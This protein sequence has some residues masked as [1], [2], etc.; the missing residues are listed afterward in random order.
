MIVSLFSEAR[1]SSPSIFYIEG[2]EVF[3]STGVSQM[4]SCENDG[5]AIVVIGTADNVKTLVKDIKD[6]FDMLVH[7]GKPDMVSRTKM[8]DGLMK[9]YVVLEDRDKICNYI[10]SGTSGMVWK[11]IKAICNECCVHVIEERETA[12]GVCSWVT[13]EDVT[14][15]LKHT[16][17]GISMLEEKDAIGKQDATIIVSSCIALVVASTSSLGILVTFCE[18][19]WAGGILPKVNSSRSVSVLAL[20]SRPYAT[21]LDVGSLMRHKTLK[22]VRVPTSFVVCRCL[23][24]KLSFQDDLI[25][26]DTPKKEIDIFKAQMEEKFEMSD[27]GLLAYY[28]GIKVTQTGGDISIKQ[29]AYANKILK[30]AGMIDSNETLI[31][32]DLGIRLSKVTEGTR[33]SRIQD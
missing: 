32:M 31:P 18:F 25:I 20:L 26:T 13:F 3:T 30:E 19:K 12:I 4:E 28:L 9:D 22:P 14:K 5:A 1:V 7:L 10:A 15:T 29:S 33:L 8:V 27:L 23:S 24:L 2:I 16:K 6:G 17:Y 21:A 11:N